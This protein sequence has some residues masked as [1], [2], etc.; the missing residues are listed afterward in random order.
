MSKPFHKGETGRRRFAPKPFHSLEL[1]H[2]MGFVPNKIRMLRT[3]AVPL[4]EAV[5]HE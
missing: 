4:I 2:S 3:K 5:P 1:F